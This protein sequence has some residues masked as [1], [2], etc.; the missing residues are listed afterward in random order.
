MALKGMPGVGRK[1]SEGI[2]THV[3]VI[4]ILFGA[5]PT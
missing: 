4:L 1:E 3:I 2:D 5:I